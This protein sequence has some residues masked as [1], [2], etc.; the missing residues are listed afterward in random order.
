[1]TLPYDFDIDVN[2]STQPILPSLQRPD[3]DVGTL[4]LVTKL[5]SSITSSDLLPSSRL[6][7]LPA[8]FR[9]PFYDLPQSPLAVLLACRHLRVLKIG[10]T[11]TLGIDDAFL[12]KI[13]LSWPGIQVL[14]LYG[15]PQDIPRV[16]LEGIRE[17]LRR[18]QHLWSLGIQID[19]RTVPEEEPDVRSPSLV[20]LNIDC[21]PVTDRRA[22]ERYL[23]ILAPK[24]RSFLHCNLPS[25]IY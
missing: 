8:D 12:T 7:I 14:Y 22:V 21:S 4:N 25:I 24:L 5:L 13:T 11:G 18:C 10:F 9:D 1:M 20:I 2:S 3:L 17:L 16:S 6:S 15:S 19:A 23:T